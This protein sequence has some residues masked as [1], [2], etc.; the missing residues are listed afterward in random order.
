MK[1]K[2]TTKI[3]FL[4]LSLIIATTNYAQCNQP[5]GIN[6]TDITSVSAVLSWSESTSAPGIAYSFEVRLSGL[7]GSGVSGLV[8]S[9]SVGDGVFTSPLSG[10]ISD[11]TYFVYMRFQCS[12]EPLFSDWTSAVT[13]TT[14]TLSSPV[15]GAPAGLSDTFFSARWIAVPGATGYRLDVSEFSDF[16]TMLAG[17]DNLFVSGSSTSRLVSGLNP[18][19]DYYYRLRAEGL[20]GSGPVTSGNSNV[21]MITT[22]NEPTFVAV[23]S[24]GAWLNDILPTAD[25]DVILD[26]DFISDENNSTMFEVKSITLN[27]GYS[28]TIT[29]G[30]SLIVYDNIINNSNAGSFVVQNN[31]NL[32]QLNDAASPNIGEITVIRNSSEI[33]RLDYTMW[34]SPV[35]GTQTLKQFSP[36]TVDSRFYEYNSS[37]DIY[38]PIDPLTSTFEPGNGYFIRSPNNHVANN[39]TNDPQRWTGT[40]IGIPTNGEV[41]VALETSGQGFNLVGNPYPTVISADVLLQQNAANIDGTIYFWRRL[42]DISGSG[43]LGSF[44]ATY[45]EFGGVGSSTSEDPNGFIQVG[46]GFLV[47][48][49]NTELVF[50]SEMK[51][52]DEFENQFFRYSTQNQMDKHRLWLNLTNENGLYSKL[53]LGYAAEASNGLDRLDGKY[54][55]DSPVALTSLLNNEEFTIQAKALPFSMDDFF[56]LGLKIVSAGEYSIAIE[57]MDGFFAEGQLVYLEDTF[58]A[59]IH[60]LSESAYVFSSEAGAFN[61]RFILRFTDEVMSVEQPFNTNAI[62]I[63]VQDNQIKI[64]AGDQ[65]IKALKVVDI[66]G[67]NLF[68]ENEINATEF[69]IN[70]LNKNNQILFFQ[71]Q[72]YN[73]NVIIKKL[74]Y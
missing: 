74:I 25:H 6:V 35:I 59:T 9:G 66:Q 27:E 5:T 3:H 56:P 13:F 73:N 40:F 47:K 20:S 18:S 10:L 1:F 7:P 42:N 36:Q 14:S 71:I 65:E 58:T 16:S 41:N 43:P 26:D 30:N 63:F 21:I 33:F 29:S 60:N 2:F 69:S 46:Q 37:D 53:L 64:N 55:N 11:T 70:S 8:D 52:P 12:S 62:S 4:I 34:S 57:N 72:D 54:I 22:F 24:E 67:R 48:A 15:A 44:Y 39:G 68:F 51:V 17:Y 32:F 31:A 61:N 45:T 23:W 49:L 19:T 50:N 28:Y 38:S